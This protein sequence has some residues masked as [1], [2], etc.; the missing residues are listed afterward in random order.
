MQTE[1]F[2]QR[3]NKLTKI[4]RVTRDC[5]QL[6]GCW[7]SLYR[8]HRNVACE[9]AQCTLG[10]LQQLLQACCSNRSSY[11]MLQHG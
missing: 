10:A 2:L 6:V 4:T 7:S 8:I 9:I 5:N 3:H 1:I 11:C